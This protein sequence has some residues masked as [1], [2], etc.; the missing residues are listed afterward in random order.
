MRRPIEM[1]RASREKN[2]QKTRALSYCHKGASGYCVGKRLARRLRT[3]KAALEQNSR[4]DE[5]R[6]QP[7]F[8]FYLRGFSHFQKTMKKNEER[9]ALAFRK[10]KN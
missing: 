5:Q 4:E 2:E 10:Q 6:Y 1:G 7:F 9:N 3:A 8:R